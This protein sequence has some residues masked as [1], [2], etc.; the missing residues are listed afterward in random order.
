MTQVAAT[1]GAHHFRAD[2]AVAVVLDFPDAVLGDA[3]VEAGPAAAGIELGGGVE[4]LCAAAFAHVGAA[5]PLRFVFAAEGPFGAFLPQHAVFFRAEALFPVFV[6]EFA[7]IGGI[8]VH[9]GLG[10]GSGLAA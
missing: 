4:Q 10:G 2:H 5:V 9:G 1:A 3:L 6:A 7:E 8:V